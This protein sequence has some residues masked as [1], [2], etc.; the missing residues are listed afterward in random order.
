MGK[1]KSSFSGYEQQDSHEFLTI[2]VDWLHEELNEVSIFSFICE[3]ISSDANYCVLKM[4]FQ[5]RIK[6]PLKEQNN[7]GIP[8]EK[9]A[10][11]AWDDYVK[12]NQSIIVSVFG[13]QQRS[14]LKCMECGQ[15]SV[16]FEPFFN[17]SLPIPES[18]VECDLMVI[19]FRS[20]G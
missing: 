7:Y 6:E 20:F 3:S 17:L 9:A 19:H 5:Q 12:S 10:K 8:D 14:S 2:L 4:L 18:A 1:Y 13:G 15:E 16:T 11:M